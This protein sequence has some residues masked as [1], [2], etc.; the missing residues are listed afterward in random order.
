MAMTLRLNEVEDM[1]LARVAERKGISKQEAAR[2]AIREFTD[3]QDRL[4]AIVRKH[5]ERLK[6]VL[7]KLK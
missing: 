7:D 1:A 5:V 4:D 2:Q 6:P 3:E